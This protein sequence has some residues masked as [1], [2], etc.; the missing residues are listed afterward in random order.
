MGSNFII[1]ENK[2]ISYFP[3]DGENQYVSYH[4]SAETIQIIA[5]P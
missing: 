2:V 5:Y 3:F 4:V 1:S